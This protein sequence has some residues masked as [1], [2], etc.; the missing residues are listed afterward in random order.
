M[1]VINTHASRTYTHTRIHFHTHTRT[2]I[3]TYARTHH[4]HTRAHIFICTRTHVHTYARTHTHTCTHTTYYTFVVFGK[5]DKN[6][7][8]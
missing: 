6:I 7:G 5:A 8:G 3:H 2:H 4:T 1:N